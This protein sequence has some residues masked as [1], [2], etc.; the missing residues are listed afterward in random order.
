MTDC[1]T[2]NPD[3]RPTFKDIKQRLTEI[4]ASKSH[5]SKDKAAPEGQIPSYLVLET[6]PITDYNYHSAKI[7][8]SQ[9]TPLKTGRI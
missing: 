5:A 6:S 1:W 7:S 3:E 4:L 2:T 8:S 9:P